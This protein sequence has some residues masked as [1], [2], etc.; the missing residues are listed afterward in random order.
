MTSIKSYGIPYFVPYA[1]DIAKDKKDGF[2][3]QDI[4]D[5]MTRP[6]LI[7]DTNKTRQRA[8]EKKK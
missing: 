2:I 6:M 8:K 4:Q 3:K 1:P 5:M 7:T